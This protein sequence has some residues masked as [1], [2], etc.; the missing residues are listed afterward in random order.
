M[1]FIDKI[2]PYELDPKGKILLATLISISL[3]LFMFFVNKICSF[4]VL[5]HEMGHAIYGTMLEGNC[6]IDLN[7]SEYNDT[8]GMTYCSLPENIPIS[9]M[10]ILS[11]SGVGAETILS[12]IF[13]SIPWISVMGGVLFFKVGTGLHFGGYNTD[14]KA[15][16]ISIPNEITF[17]F[18]IFSYMV[19][20]VSG[21]ITIWFWKRELEK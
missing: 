21:I 8:A 17:F 14:I 16:G 6:S 9:K 2:L 20:I 5:I 18:F 7:P 12:L 13:L 19:F 1:S 3:G 10:R 11:L 15:I 4:N